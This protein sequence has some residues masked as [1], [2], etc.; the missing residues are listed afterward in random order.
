MQK[1]NDCHGVDNGTNQNGKG[2]RPDRIILLLW[3]P[4]DFQGDLVYHQ[5][6]NTN[7]GGKR[8]LLPSRANLRILNLSTASPHAVT[9]ASVNETMFNQMGMTDQEAVSYAASIQTLQADGV[10]GRC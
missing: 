3:P 9:A 2:Y 10:A 8:R 6:G 5:I 4:I 1:E 7:P